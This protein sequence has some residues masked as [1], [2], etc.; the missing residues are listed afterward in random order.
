[1][2][3]VFEFPYR[4]VAEV[5]LTRIIRNLVHLRT[6]SRKEVIPVIKADAYGHGMIPVAKVLLARGSCTMVAV[7]TLEEAIELRKHFDRPFSILV[8]SGFLPH[9][10]STQ[11]R[12]R[13][14]H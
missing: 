14:D 5:S 2:A 8:L 3:K 4:T 13:R 10:L 7:A 12:F 6:F 9:Q 11:R 1:M